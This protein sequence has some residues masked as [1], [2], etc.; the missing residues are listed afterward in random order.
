MFREM[1]S[2]RD[3]FLGISRLSVI[4]TAA[5]ISLYLLNPLLFKIFVLVLVTVD[6]TGR[7]PSG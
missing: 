5:K 3:R 7:C 1:T 2:Q 4:Q 6:A